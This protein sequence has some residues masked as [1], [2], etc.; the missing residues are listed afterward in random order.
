M[1]FFQ[2]RKE[3]H[4]LVAKTPEFLENQIKNTKI[5]MN[6]GFMLFDLICY[7][8]FLVLLTTKMCAAE[9]G[10]LAKQWSMKQRTEVDNYGIMK[11]KK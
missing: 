5:K 6:R 11:L 2:F 10:K 9:E 7:T 3:F 1:S 4:S 8:M